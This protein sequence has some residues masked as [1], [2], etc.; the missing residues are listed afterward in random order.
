M[1]MMRNMIGDPGCAIGTKYRYLLL[2]PV[3]LFITRGFDAEKPIIL[4]L[5]T[6]IPIV[7]IG[8][9]MS[10]QTDFYSHLPLVTF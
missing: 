8:D 7:V 3:P 9:F 10:P 5:N 2:E 6:V 4:V 1:T